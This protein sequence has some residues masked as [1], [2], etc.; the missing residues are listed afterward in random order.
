MRMIVVNPSDVGSFVRLKEDVVG[1]G[2]GHGV[3]IQKKSARVGNSSDLQPTF[4]EW[5]KSN[6]GSYYSFGDPGVNLKAWSLCERPER[7]I[8]GFFP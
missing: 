8:L 5:Q 4:F 2:N 6:P 3:L 1:N 7:V